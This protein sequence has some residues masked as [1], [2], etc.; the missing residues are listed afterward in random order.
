MQS[1]KETRRYLGIGCGNF[2]FHK[3]WLLVASSERKKNNKRATGLRGRK[4]WVLYARSMIASPLSFL[5]E[6][7]GYFFPS[8]VSAQRDVVRWQYCSRTGP[9]SHSLSAETAITCRAKGAQ[10]KISWVS[11][12]LERVS[13][14]AVSAEYS[15][16]PQPSY[17]PQCGTLSF[18]LST[19]IF[20]IFC[21]LLSVH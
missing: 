7:G 5:S 12:W 6:A 1:P 18:I 9:G 4:D 20:L 2:S 16:S 17:A 14:L 15:Y 21:L 8:M 19:L 3:C 13:S 10:S 11:W